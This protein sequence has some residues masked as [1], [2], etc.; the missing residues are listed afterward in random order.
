M[1]TMHCVSK[2]FETTCGTPKFY[3]WYIRA[4]GYPAKARSQARGLGLGTFQGSGRGPGERS[5]MY[6]AMWEAE[7]CSVHVFLWPAGSLIGGH[8]VVRI[9]LSVRY[10]TTWS[11]LISC[12]C[13][14]ALNR[15]N[16]WFV[17]PFPA[18]RCRAV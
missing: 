8:V 7:R 17:L 1:I 5:S 15:A 9:F 4:S 13:R 3:A 14:P 12:S 6:R 16:V 11:D 2:R 10:W 18:Q